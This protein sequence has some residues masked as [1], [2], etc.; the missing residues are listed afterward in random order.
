[1]VHA[2]ANGTWRETL[3][4]GTVLRSKPATYG[5]GDMAV[6][7]QE[8]VIISTPVELLAQRRRDFEAGYD[9]GEGGQSSKDV[10]FATHVEQNP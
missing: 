1:M 3:I 4:N 6:S 2:W 10:T 8:E 9:W 7:N 5:L